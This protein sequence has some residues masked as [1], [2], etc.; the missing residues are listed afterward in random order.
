MKNT[1]TRFLPTRLRQEMR[2]VHP[3]FRLNKQ[4]LM[5]Q[6]NFHSAPHKIPF[7]A[8]VGKVGEDE[9]QFGIALTFADHLEKIE[10]FKGKY[11]ERLYH[12]LSLAY[13]ACRAFQSASADENAANE[14]ILNEKCAAL[15]IEG[16][17]YYQKI[18]KITFNDDAKRASS[19]V[20]VIKV[21]EKQKIEAGEFAKW[22][23]YKGGIQKIRMTLNAD[24]SEKSQSNQSP[25]NTIQKLIATAKAVVLNDSLATIPFGGIP[26]IAKLGN[27][28]EYPAI[29]RQQADGSYVVKHISLDEKIVD[30][31]YAAHGRTLKPKS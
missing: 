5:L 17:S 8:Q 7:A 15:K 24:G 27:E 12:M 14:N 13:A 25:K 16:S 6:N 18:V 30:A 21:A 1:A 2:S 4:R 26:I 19:F 22:L 11:R 31:I 20:H 9:N 10:Q 3:R 23:E 29:L 28:A